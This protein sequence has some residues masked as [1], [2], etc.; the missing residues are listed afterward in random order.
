MP[1]LRTLHAAPVRPGW[2]FWVC[3]VGLGL[4]GV[5]AGLRTSKVTDG[6]HA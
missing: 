5:L 1:A 3:A 2:G 6:Q 4:M